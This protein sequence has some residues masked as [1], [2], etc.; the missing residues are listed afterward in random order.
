M[1]MSAMARTFSLG[2]T[3]IVP[4][5]EAIAELSGAINLSPNENIFTVGQNFQKQF[6]QHSKHILVFAL[7]TIHLNTETCK[8]RTMS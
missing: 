1:F 5:N 8:D 7:D 4:I 6:I 3:L 2:E